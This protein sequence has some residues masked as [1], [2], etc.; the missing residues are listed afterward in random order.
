MRHSCI[1]NITKNYQNYKNSD[2][3]LK[4]LTLSEDC[5]QQSPYFLKITTRYVDV[6]LNLNY[7]DLGRLAK[8]A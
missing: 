3:F 8:I 7:M 1:L 5:C 2:S 4:N 6:I